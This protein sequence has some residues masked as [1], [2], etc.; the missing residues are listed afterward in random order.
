V[1]NCTF[2]SQARHR[3]ASSAAQK[4]IAAALSQASQSVRIIEV[5]GVLFCMIQEREM[6]MFVYLLLKIQKQ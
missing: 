3:A 2:L 4:T 1:E 6:H 5:E